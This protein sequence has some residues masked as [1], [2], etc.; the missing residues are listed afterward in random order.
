M[1]RAQSKSLK[2]QKWFQSRRLRSM[3]RRRFGFKT[4]RTLVREYLK[5]N[6]DAPLKIKIDAESGFAWQRSQWA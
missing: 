5:S 3:A 1:F 2:N 4:E 6:R